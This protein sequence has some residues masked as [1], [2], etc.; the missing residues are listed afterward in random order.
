MA[1]S[2]S[3]VDRDR[4][5]PRVPP[6]STG[7]AARRKVACIPRCLPHSADPPNLLYGI[8]QGHGQHKRTASLAGSAGL[9][10]LF[11]RELILYSCGVVAKSRQG[12]GSVRITHA[13][14]SAATIA[15]AASTVVS[16][17]TDVRSLHRATNLPCTRCI[18]RG[19][20]G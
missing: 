16:V 10:Y 4:D 18:E 2:R 8:H 13:S 5:T 6:E 15:S 11:R 17:A 12:R 9:G 7:R 1:H 20:L 19:V 3:G 14:T